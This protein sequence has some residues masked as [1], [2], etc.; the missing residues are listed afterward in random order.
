ACAFAVLYAMAPAAARLIGRPLED[1]SEKAVYAAPALLFV[2]VAIA[3]IEPATA[4]P[5]KLFGPMFGLV[6]L[7]AWRA[8]ATEAYALDF[9]AAFFTVAA[10]AVWSA[11]YFTADHLAA[12]MALY[13]AFGVFYL[14]VPV[15]ARRVGRAIEPAW[16]GGAVLISSLLLLLFVASGPQSS[17]S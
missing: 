12:G 9:V 1:A 13:A 3:S 17:D 10:E 6:A 16:G 15:I 7:I 4:A 5:L 14:S 11:K 8:L 2:F